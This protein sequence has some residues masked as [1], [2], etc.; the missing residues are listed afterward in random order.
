MNSDQVVQPY[1]AD[2]PQWRYPIWEETDLAGIEIDLGV[3]S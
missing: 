3:R 1:L 2:R